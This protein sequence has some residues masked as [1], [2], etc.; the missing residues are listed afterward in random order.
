MN[1]IMQKPPSLFQSENP[2][3]GFS[4]DASFGSHVLLR[5]SGQR[6]V[7]FDGGERRQT[8]SYKF[9]ELKPL[10]PRRISVC[11]GE[12]VEVEERTSPNEVNPV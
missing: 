3:L 8:L 6:I 11:K 1:R 10:N 12:L 2:R 9:S 4:M 5:N 7:P